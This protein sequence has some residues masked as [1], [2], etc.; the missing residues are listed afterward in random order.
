MNNFEKFFAEY[1]NMDIDLLNG[2]LFDYVKSPSV[3]GTYVPIAE[4]PYVDEYELEERYDQEYEQDYGEPYKFL[5]FEPI[6]YED[7][8][9]FDYSADV[10]YVVASTSYGQNETFFFMGDKDGA[11]GVSELGCSMAERW[12]NPFWNMSDKIDE[13]INDYFNGTHDIKLIGTQHIAPDK[14]C[15]WVVN[16]RIYEVTKRQ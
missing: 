9:S 14:Y 13:A 7:Y 3:N 1:P 10:Q 5:D 16:K 6:D 12:G 15:S 8:D 2:L 4:D 11:H